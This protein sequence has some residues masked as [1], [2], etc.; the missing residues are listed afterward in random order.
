MNDSIKKSQFSIG[1]ISGTSADGIDAALVRTNGLSPP[2]FIAARTFSYPDAVR[3][4]ILDLYQPGPGEIDRMGQLDRTLGTLF[5]DAARAVC[6]AAGVG[7]KQVR[8]IGSH[9]QTVRHRPPDFTLQIG[10]PFVIAAETGVTTVADFRPA[11]LARGGEGAPLVPLFHHCLFAEPGRDVAVV[12]LGG[13]ANVT[14]LPGG[15]GLSP[16]SGDTGPANALLDLFA[17]R[18]SQGARRHDHDGLRASRGRAAPD[19]LAW[20]LNL[21]YLARPFPKS[22]GRE[23]FGEALLQRFLTAFPQLAADDCFATLTEFT[24]VTVANA[25]RHLLPPAPYRLVPCGGGANNPVMVRRIAACL[26]ATRITPSTLLGVDADS[27]EAQAFAWFALRTLRGLPSSLPGATGARCG[28]VL[29]AVY[30][31]AD[32]VADR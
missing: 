5:S 19:A 16:V 13:L 6:H 20:L 11:D 31:G 9:G 25:C 14:A 30:R 1:L 23:V 27:L 32:R 2:R 18:E 28:A 7:L 26:P 4:E 12:N 29:G 21:P 10:N 24:A 22:T 17:T 8:V 3:R 15:T